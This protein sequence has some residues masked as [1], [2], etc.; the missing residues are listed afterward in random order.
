[1]HN[2]KE[3]GKDLSKE[4]FLSYWQK[5]PWFTLFTNIKIEGKLKSILFV[6]ICTVERKAIII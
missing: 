1:M 3:R 5:I 4:L 2:R 6:D